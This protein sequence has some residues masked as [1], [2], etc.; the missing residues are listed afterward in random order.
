[1]LART[2]SLATSSSWMAQPAGRD[3]KPA[4]DLALDAAAGAADDGAKA[5][6][7]AKRPVRLADEVED[8][9]ALLFV[10]AAQP[11]A[12]LLEEQG[13]AL[14]GAQEQDGVDVGDVDAFVEEVDAEEDA[15]LAGGEIAE[16]GGALGFGGGGGDGAGAQAGALELLRHE[17]RVALVDAE[18]EGAHLGDVGDAGVRA[19]G[20]RA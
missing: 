19:L 15:E 1:M 3:G 11:A 10:A 4:L 9:E 16:R 13:G 7:E 8:G 6:V 12:E 18:A 17:V 14:G 5:R 2:C 20:G